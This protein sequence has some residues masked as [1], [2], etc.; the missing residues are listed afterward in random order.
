M[1]VCAFGGV[2]GSYRYR[3]GDGTETGD[4][5]FAATMRSETPS[6]GARSLARTRCAPAEMERREAVGTC[7]PRPSTRPATAKSSYTGAYA[8]IHPCTNSVE[9]LYNIYIHI[10]Y[11]IHIYTLYGFQVAQHI[12]GPARGDA[13]SCHRQP[14]RAGG[15]APR[16]VVLGQYPP[17]HRC[18]NSTGGA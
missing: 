6:R 12:P 14:P 18:P 8:L 5:G 10:I 9:N 15:P 16:P 1:K 11:R 3:N 13:R 7:A 2:C 4:R 17:S